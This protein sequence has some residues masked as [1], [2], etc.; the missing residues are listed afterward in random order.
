MT[1]SISCALRCLPCRWAAVCGWLIPVLLVS[2]LS[3]AERVNV[4][5]RPANIS[6]LISPSLLTA[7]TQLRAQHLARLGVDRW[8]AAGY[9]GQGIKVAILDT[10]WRG[11]Q[12]HLG[13]ALPV[14]VIAHSFRADGNLEAKNSQHGILCAEV[15]HSLA[16]DAEL[17]LANWDLDRPDEYLHAVRWARTQGAR[18]ISCSVVAPS[19][20]NGEGGGTIHQ[21]LAHLLGNGTRL[22]DL[23][24]FASAGNTTERHWFGAFHDSGHGIHEWAPGITDNSL[25]PWNEETCAAEIYGPPGADYEMS[26]RDSDSGVEVGHAATVQ[27][28]NGRNSAA[29]RFPPQLGHTYSLRV[30]RL[31]G[32]DG[33]FH[34]CTGNSYLGCTTS[35]SSV[36]FPGDGPEVV[37]MGAVDARDR[38]AAYSACGPNSPQTKPDLVAPIPFPSL[39]R[40][41][42]F[43]GTSAAAPQGAGLAALVWSRHRNWTAAQVRRRPSSCGP[44]PWSPRT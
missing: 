20:S 25:S 19:W 12:I 8:H 38:R 28:G 26:V 3:A 40:E 27:D 24:C 31:R 4:S 16:P 18:I 2:G 10:G 11:Y 14:H 36:C 34:L 39:W 37:A 5:A 44:R 1:F 29:I 22:G 15:L 30:R 21:S 23:L 6:T 9:R 35:R 42:L 7:R 13:G 32:A 33:V 41:K 43:A 17:L